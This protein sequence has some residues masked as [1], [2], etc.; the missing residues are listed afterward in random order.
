MTKR[1]VVLLALF[2][3]VPGVLRAQSPADSAAIT[4]TA[5]D[6]IEGWYEGNAERMERALHPELAKRMVS[7]DPASGSSTLNHMT[8][9]QLVAATGA[10]YGTRTPEAERR[11]DLTILDIYENVASV[12]VVARD[13]IDYL[14]LA[15][16]D[17][18]WVIINVLWELTPEAK[19]Q[20]G[21]GR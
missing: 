8:A 17:N 6:Y 19:Q 2:P 13:W 12:K 1:L 10:G 16:F 20:M 18:S 11:R 4:R 3:I 5:L 9:Q 14:H 15:K 21:G 7:T